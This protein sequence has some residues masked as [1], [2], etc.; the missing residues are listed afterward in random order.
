MLT[1]NTDYLANIYDHDLLA[2]FWEKGERSTQVM[3]V[4]INMQ[5][6]AIF[7]GVIKPELS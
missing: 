2:V 6:H 5:M 3:K 7:L 1:C 4:L